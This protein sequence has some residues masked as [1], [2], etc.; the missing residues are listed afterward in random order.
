MRGAS[1]AIVSK[2]GRDE[3]D[4]VRTPHN[5]FT[6]GTDAHIG[7]THFLCGCTSAI[8]GIKR[9]DV[10]CLSGGGGKLESLPEPSHTVVWWQGSL[11]DE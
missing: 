1:T 6:V 3:R 10:R 2:S 9:S 11:T 5:V 7:G 8:E 4:T